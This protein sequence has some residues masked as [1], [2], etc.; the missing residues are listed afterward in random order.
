MINHK[1]NKFLPELICIV[2]EVIIREAKIIL[3]LQYDK[4]ELL[5]KLLPESD[6][7][8]HV[9]DGKE[10]ALEPDRYLHYTKSGS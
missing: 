3:F 7:I 6:Y 9:G 1:L 8:L 2:L 5:A 4:F 10:V